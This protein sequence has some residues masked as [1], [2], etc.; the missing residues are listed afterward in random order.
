MKSAEVAGAVMKPAVSMVL[1]GAG[2]GRADHDAVRRVRKDHA[3]RHRLCKY[4]LE[5]EK[6]GER[7]NNN[8]A[9]AASAL[10]AK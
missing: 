10:A 9:D 1:N 2:V 7:Y 4:C 5:E 3:I 8:A 6:I